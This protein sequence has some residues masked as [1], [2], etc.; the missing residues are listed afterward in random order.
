MQ[1]KVNASVVKIEE[2]SNMIRG[3]SEK[4]LSKI[5][6]FQSGMMLGE[7]KQLAHENSLRVDQELKEQ[8]GDH[9]A[10]RKTVM[11]V[12]RDFDINLVR[13][14]TMRTAVFQRPS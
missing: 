2:S 13:N 4:T 6:D 9:D 11:G 10:I 8:F 14:S 7:Q 5:S 1:D 3:T 12:V